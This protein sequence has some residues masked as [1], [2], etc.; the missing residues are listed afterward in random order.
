[1]MAAQ[2]GHEVPA[3]AAKLMEFSEKAKENDERYAQITAQNAVAV[4]DRQQRSRA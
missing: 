2:R 3:I 1:M 4:V